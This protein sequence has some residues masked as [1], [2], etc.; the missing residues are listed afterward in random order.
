MPLDPHAVR[1]DFPILH[2]EIGGKPLV[3]LD[4][5]APTQ[6]PES[7]IAAVRRY[8]EED[9]ANVHRGIYQLSQRAT[10][11]F[12]AAR[13]KV[14][15]WIGAED[16][17]QVVWTRGATESLNLVAMSWGLEH[18]AEGDEIVLTE[19]DHHS[20]LVPWQLVARR[21]GARLRYIPLDEQGK[22]DLGALPGLLGPR[23]RVV[24]FSHVSN[25]LGTINPVREIAAAARAV[26]ALVVVDG[27]QG[28]PHTPVRVS[29]LDCDFY[30]FSGHKMLGPT[31]IGALWG[32]KEVLEAMPPYQGGGEMILEVEREMS[33]WAG[34]PHKFEAGTPNIAGAVGMGAAVDYL[35]DLGADD[36]ARHERDITAYALERLAEFPGIR[37][38]GP[39]GTDDRAGVISFNLK[40]A[41]PHDVATILDSEGIAIRAG[42]HCAQ[43][44]MKRYGVPATNRASFYI[45][46]TN[47]DVDRLVDGLAAV[48]AVFG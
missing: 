15:G 41:H 45:Y 31:G 36:I 1:S 32:R 10:D 24:S 19:Q 16:P 40:S 5:A 12:E 44:T 34:L 4:N 3:Y 17:R 29:E 9:N 21:T 42:H 28:A 8:Y 35:T 6:K 7:V 20:N 38:F 37:I 22:L 11:A 27:A 2:Q 43:L 33:T 46:N 47:D 25:A 14:A 26:G 39:P 30:A 13:V 18:L 23:T 48:T